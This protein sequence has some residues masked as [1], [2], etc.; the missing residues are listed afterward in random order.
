MGVARIAEWMHKVNLQVARSP[1][2]RHFLLE[3]SGHVS[4]V[5]AKIQHEGMETDIRQPRERKGSNFFTEIR[6]GLATFFAMAYIIS[7]NANLTS[8]SG[9]TCVCPPESQADHCNSNTEYLLC[10]QEVHRDAVTATA[11]I[12]SLSTFFMGLLSNLPV[13]LAPGMGLN[14]YF[15]YTVV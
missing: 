2:G 7:V 9:G 6:A 4:L 13:A 3:G 1:V 10:V 5:V 14:A 15:A 12:A 8:E 11:A